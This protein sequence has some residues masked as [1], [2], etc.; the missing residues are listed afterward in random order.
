MGISSIRIVILGLMLALLGWGCGSKKSYYVPPPADTTVDIKYRFTPTLDPTSLSYVYIPPDLDSA[1][2]ELD[3]ILTPAFREELKAVPPKDMTLYRGQL[4]LWIKN[5]W[6]LWSAS[7]LR[8]YFKMRGLNH[9]DDMSALILD[10]YWCHLQGS[11]PDLPALEKYYQIKRS[12]IDSLTR[13]ATD[14]QPIPDLPRPESF[15]K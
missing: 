2:D 1:L 13:R 10:A 9:A 11:S 14:I 6:G 15:C 7:P 5:K 3:R 12:C 8:S 4:G